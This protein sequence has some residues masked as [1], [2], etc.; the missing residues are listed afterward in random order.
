M[1][2]AQ[3]V[4]DGE[5]GVGGRRPGVRLEVDRVR[6]ERASP[7]A[8]PPL[9]LLLV[10]GPALVVG[11]AGG[12]APRRPRRGRGT[13]ASGSRRRAGSPGCAPSIPR[14]YMHPTLGPSVA[15]WS[16]R[17]VYR[18]SG[19]RAAPSPHSSQ[20]SGIR[21]RSS[22]SAPFH[23]VGSAARRGAA[24]GH[25]ELEGARGARPS[26]RAVDVQVAG[27]E[28]DVLEQQDPGGLH[29][30]GARR[31]AAGPSTS[32]RRT[33]GRATGRVSSGHRIGCRVAGRV[34]ARAAA[35]PGRAPARGTAG[36]SRTKEPRSVT[37]A[38]AEAD[39]GPRPAPR[40]APRSPA[41][42]P[43]TR[44]PVER[45]A[46]QP[47]RRGRHHGDLDGEGGVGG[48]A[49]AHVADPARGEEAADQQ[50]GAPPVVARG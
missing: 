31:E 3:L 47:H 28:P 1:G 32:G 22:P 43:L 10:D 2:T 16:A 17:S 9:E 45:G 7:E 27:G 40:P 41:R 8:E 23:A 49:D 39:C 33:R 29:D 14:R 21:R 12:P 20:V 35:R 15:P 30:L 46:E 50:A 37:R 42:A 13:G 4:V 18:S 38:A 5:L 26:Q 24:A 19:D 36:S 6:V 34:H 44:R 25:P 48:E 11:R